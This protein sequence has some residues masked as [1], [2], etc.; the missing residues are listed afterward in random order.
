MKQK[1]INVAESIKFIQEFNVA[2][3][4]RNIFASKNIDSTGFIKAADF[5][6]SFDILN[7]KVGIDN[8][9]MGQK[10]Y[11]W[12][13][14][15]IHK[16]ISD[17]LNLEESIELYKQMIQ[18]S[19]DY[20]CCLQPTE[21]NLFTLIKKHTFE[22][23]IHSLK[24]INALIDLDDHNLY[25]TIGGSCKFLIS[26][27]NFDVVKYHKDT[28]SYFVSCKTQNCIYSA[29]ENELIAIDFNL[30]TIGTVEM[31]DKHTD[32][33]TNVVY[34]GNNRLATS[35]GDSTIK[36]WQ[37]ESAT[38]MTHISTLKKH[39]S[40]VITIL[41]PKNSDN[42]I[43]CSYDNKLIVW[44]L[45]KY[46]VIHEIN[47]IQ[48]LFINGVKELNRN[49]IIV[50]GEKILSIIDYYKGE[51]I[52]RIPIETKATCF[53]IING[54]L[55]AGCFDGSYLTIDIENYEVKAKDEKE[56]NYITSLLKIPNN[57]LVVGLHNG[58]LKIYSY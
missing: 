11:E 1:P 28:F 39:T 56:T 22:G 26:K 31:D 47:D 6:S 25:G 15:L 16:K 44:D 29:K 30:E 3:Y 41:K 24:S 46:S 37:I 43:S 8:K 13:L 54:N 5:R 20:L 10:E 49:R 32:W 42:L 50:S 48:C 36:I 7:E 4:V 33:I 27:S 18:I 34:L 52:H 51:V 58:I 45:K 55:L 57:I 2:E 23:D 14:N 9:I 38:K 21:S 17:N 35:S 40:S 12:M 19:T 53:E